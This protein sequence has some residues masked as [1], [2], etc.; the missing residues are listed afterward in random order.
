MLFAVEA[1]G[2]AFDRVRKDFWREFPGDAEGRAFADALVEAT[3][4]ARADVDERITAASNHWRLERMSRVD[5]NVLRLA[6][7]ELLNH[8]DVPAPVILDEAV[9]LAKR[10]GSAESGAF[11]NGV[12]SRIAAECGRLGESL[13]SPTEGC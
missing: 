5:R 2:E 7:L 1:S 3:L 10:Y 11:V 9:D 12:L 8:R 6:T 4:A 13:P